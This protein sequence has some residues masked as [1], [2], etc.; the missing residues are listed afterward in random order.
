MMDVFAAYAA[1]AAFAVP[2][3]KSCLLVLVTTTVETRPL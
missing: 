1:Y 2:V 3:F